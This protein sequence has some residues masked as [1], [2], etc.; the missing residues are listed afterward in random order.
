MSSL[1][2]KNSF[3]SF[4]SSIFHSKTYKHPEFK[5]NKDEQGGAGQIFEVLSEHTF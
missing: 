2:K 3:L 5:M 1:Q 4:Q